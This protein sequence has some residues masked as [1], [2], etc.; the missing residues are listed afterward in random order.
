MKQ[1]SVA[2]AAAAEEQS[3]AT[4]SIAENVNHAAGR[5]EDARN[6]VAA[7]TTVTE[8]TREATGSVQESARAVG[9]LSDSLTKVARDFLDK[10]R[11]A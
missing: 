10:L 11:A 9:E 4:N 2:V 6:S 7:M 5:S 1:L 3:A 8:K